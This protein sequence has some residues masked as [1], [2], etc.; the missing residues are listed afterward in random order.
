MVTVYTEIKAVSKMLCAEILP[1]E[2]AEK[3][4]KKNITIWVRNW[5]QR[6]GATDTTFKKIYSEDPREYKAV[7]RLTPA[8]VE[9]LLKLISRMFSSEVLRE[10]L[11]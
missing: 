7:M 10:S 4:K 9:I 3:K 11:F 6:K 8:Q 2:S 5:M 1:A